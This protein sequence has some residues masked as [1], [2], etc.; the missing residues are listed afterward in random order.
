MHPLGVSPR[1]ETHPTRRTG[2]VMRF[3]WLVFARPVFAWTVFACTAFAWLVSGGPGTPARAQSLL[4]ETTPVVASPVVQ[5][6]VVQQP[7]VTIPVARHG[8][9]APLSTDAATLAGIDQAK[10]WQNAANAAEARGQS[11][12]A[13]ELRWRALS[14]LPNESAANDTPYT[15]LREALMLALRAWLIDLPSLEAQE[16]ALQNLEKRATTRRS[17]SSP[18]LSPSTG[19][20][21]SAASSAGSSSASDSLSGWLRAQQPQLALSLLLRQQRFTQAASYLEQLPFHPQKNRWRR[22]LQRQLREVQNTNLQRIGVL[23]P[24]SSKH[25]T[26]R[27]LAEETLDGLRLP[28]IVDHASPPPGEDTPVELII[29]DIGRA[30]SQPG[31]VAARVR[32]L[33]FTHQVAAIIGP[34]TRR[35]SEEA[36]AEAERLRVPLISLSINFIPPPGKPH[37]P[38]W[39]YR[40]GISEATEAHWLAAWIHDYLG[41]KRLALLYPQGAYGRRMTRHFFEAFEREGGE[42]RFV[43][44]FPTDLSRRQNHDAL[45]RT[46]KT[47]SGLD[48]PL[49]PEEETLLRAAGERRPDGNPPIDGLFLPL[50]PRSASLLALLAAYPSTFDLEQLPFFGS[51]YWNDPQMLIAADGRLGEVRFIA[52]YDH[53]SDEDDLRRFREAHDAAFGYR[54]NYRPPSSYTAVAFDTQRWLLSLLRLPMVRSR[55]ALSAMLQKTPHDGIT[56]RT[57]FAANGQAQKQPRLFS[58]QDELRSQSLTS[59]A[60]KSTTPEAQR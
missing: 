42:I 44:A 57:A 20:S 8:P 21:S 51:R 27:Q 59:P 50:P 54:L 18:A 5:Q 48:R 26:L 58:L 24:L 45:S 31:A 22:H 19:P 28:L 7:V 25:R 12:I 11:L 6:P 53:L 17:P 39:S 46:L 4:S 56:G 15:A 43:H 55:A 16:T 35:A 32:S 23:L 3:A 33:V 60:P 2:L 36:A 13:A 10:A 9:T 47:L 52:F 1:M 40:H 38:R 34:L 37:T 41:L 30:R 14:I 29:E 49:D